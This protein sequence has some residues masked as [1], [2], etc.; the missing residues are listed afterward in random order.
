MENVKRDPIAGIK[1]WIKEAKSE[2]KKVVWPSFAKVRQN[3]MIV[4]IY[5]IIVGSVIWLLDSG[6]IALM[7]FMP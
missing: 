4:F 2:F 7:G 5:I 1:K 3:T 6:F